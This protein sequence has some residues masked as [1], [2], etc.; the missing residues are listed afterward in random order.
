MTMDLPEELKEKSTRTVTYRM[1]NYNLF[2]MGAGMALFI[3]MGTA[4][5]F[6][7]WDK[8]EPVQMIAVSAFGFL[9][10]FMLF[11]L[12]LGN[13]VRYEVGPES[14]T[15]VPVFGAGGCLAWK[16]VSKFDVKWISTGVLEM[17]L[18]GLKGGPIRMDTKIPGVRELSVLVQ[19]HLSAHG[20]HELLETFSKQYQELVEKRF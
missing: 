20:R 10:A 1:R 4:L 8:K 9:M 17:R 7:S 5:L 19:F 3:A 18:W 14:I 13:R 6:T 16:D 2:V 12:A 15:F 11:Y